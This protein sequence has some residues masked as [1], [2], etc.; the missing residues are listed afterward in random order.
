MIR[1]V[2]LPMKPA[3]VAT[4]RCLVLGAPFDAL[5]GALAAIAQVQPG[6]EAGWNSTAT[7]RA[8]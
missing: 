6:K 4:L 8:T 1:F 3:R 7:I 5:I 2:G